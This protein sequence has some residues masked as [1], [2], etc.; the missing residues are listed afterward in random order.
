[1]ILVFNTGTRIDHAQALLCGS[2]QIRTGGGKL[3]QEGLIHGDVRDADGNPP[4]YVARHD[5]WTGTHAATP[6]LLTYSPP[7]R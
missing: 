5:A 4:G 2:Y 1:M 7:Y 6:Q 3:R